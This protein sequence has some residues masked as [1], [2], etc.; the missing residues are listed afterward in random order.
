MPVYTWCI[1]LNGFKILRKDNLK[2]PYKKADR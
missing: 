1:S 2:G